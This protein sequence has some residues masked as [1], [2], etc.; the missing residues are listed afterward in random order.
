MK[1]LRGRNGWKK[2]LDV[3]MMLLLLCLMAYQ[4]TGEA[5]HEWFGIAMTVLLIVHHVL[6]GRWYPALF[7]GKVRAW[8]AL[9]A[10]VDLLLLATVVLTALCGMAMSGHAVPILY[11]LLPGIFARRFHL[12]MS[13]WSFVLT[14]LHLG[15]HVPALKA[16]WKPGRTAETVLAALFA[17][18][19]GTGLW[20][21]VKN[22]IP[23][24]LLFR[25]PFAFFDYGK[26]ATLVF[27][28]NLAVLVF[29]AFAGALATSVL[30]QGKGAG[31]K[32]TDGRSS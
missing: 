23:D 29:F 11:G 25:T 4:V 18:A 32:R 5:L 30:R 24:Y 8:R 3:V 6:N 15:L 21:F 1:K 31:N 14:G 10:A 16:G 13:F 2:L 26:P 9:T 17:A 22:G 7:R 28:E 12:A 27:L 20:L 19:A